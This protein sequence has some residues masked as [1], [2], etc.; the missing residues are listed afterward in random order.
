MSRPMHVTGPLRERSPDRSVFT[1]PED[2]KAILAVLDGDDCR[3]ILEATDEEPMTATELSD[4]LD[5]PL[6]TTYRKLEELTDA[7]FVDGG[8]RLDGTGTHATEYRNVLEDV[9]VSVDADRGTT[10]RVAT[11]E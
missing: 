7:G 2:V 1:D 9:S 10:V 5:L 11:R 3:A 4:A 6:S 8:P